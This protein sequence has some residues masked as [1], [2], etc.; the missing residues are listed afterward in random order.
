MIHYRNGHQG[1]RT[2]FLELVTDLGGI[3]AQKLT[4]KSLT[5]SNRGLSP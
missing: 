2:E 5:K 3:K 4:P 1:K